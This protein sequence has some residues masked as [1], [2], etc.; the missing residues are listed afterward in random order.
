MF[1]NP[2]V[3]RATS[4]QGC[5]GRL[6]E[7]SCCKNCCI[8]FA[9]AELEVAYTFGYLSEWIHQALMFVSYLLL[10]IKIVRERTCS[11]ESEKEK[12]EVYEMTSLLLAK[13]PWSCVS[14][15][16]SSCVSYFKNAEANEKFIPLFNLLVFILVMTC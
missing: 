5:R 12:N 7:R 14:Y 16:T 15:F 6:F 11:N 2:D 1:P 4:K 8:K 13:L 10:L 9:T 3:G